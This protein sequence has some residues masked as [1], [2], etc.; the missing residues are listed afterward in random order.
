MLER[1]HPDRGPAGFQGG[2]QPAG[3]PNRVSDLTEGSPC[4]SLK[5]TGVPFATFSKIFSLAGF[6]AYAKGLT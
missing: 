2:A 4:S 6:V 5:M 1:N 3:T